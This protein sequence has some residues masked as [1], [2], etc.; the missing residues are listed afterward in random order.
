MKKGCY[1]F[2]NVQ[3]VWACHAV[4]TKR[5]QQYGGQEGHTQIR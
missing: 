4:D 3:W 1:G 5:K 2:T